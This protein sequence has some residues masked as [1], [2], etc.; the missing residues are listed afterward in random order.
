MTTHAPATAT[1]ITSRNTPTMPIMYRLAR[2]RLAGAAW[3][4]TSSGAGSCS[5]A[6]AR[7][8]RTGG[9]SQA[10]GGSS[11][12]RSARDG[13]SGTGEPGAFPS[14]EPGAFLS[15]EPGAFLSGEPGAFLSGEPGA[16]LS[17][18]PG[19]FLSGEPGALAPGGVG[20]GGGTAF[21]SARGPGVGS[22]VCT[23]GRVDGRCAFGALRRSVFGP[24][25]GGVSA[26]GGGAAGAGPEARRA[27]GGAD[28]Q[29]GA[30]GEPAA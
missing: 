6:P 9:G 12:G 26:A 24:G 11:T 13:F 14:G 25:A 8:R 1:P 19:A 15:G 17:G 16:F 29:S 4:T 22:G 30:A 27:G 5:A 20:G 2:R 10:P 28:C 7:P 23:P 21:C 18:E 3:G